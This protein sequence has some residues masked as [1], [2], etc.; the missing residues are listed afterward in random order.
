MIFIGEELSIFAV[1]TKKFVCIFA[2][3][4]NIFVF[5]CYVA[6]NK[7]VEMA[8]SATDATQANIT[9]KKRKRL[10]QPKRK[11]ARIQQEIIASQNVDRQLQV[12]LIAINKRI[13][14]LQGA[15][16]RRPKAKEVC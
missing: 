16:A 10:A 4:C 9:C 14:K 6:E 11:R 13:T 3:A 12:Q 1:A 7:L 8:T 15:Q 5:I 2:V